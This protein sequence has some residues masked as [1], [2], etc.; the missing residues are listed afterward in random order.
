V[1]D[2]KVDY[3]VIQTA[4]D[5]CKNAGSELQATFDTLQ[6]QLKP[7][8]DGWDGTGQAAYYDKQKNWNNQH[9]EMNQI[10]AQI[11][12]VLPQIAEGYQN[13]ES[14]VTNLF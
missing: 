5:D 14:G 7:L 4:A 9:D 11:A 12:A 8:I 10:L 3:N 13:T 2:I 1:P 6:G